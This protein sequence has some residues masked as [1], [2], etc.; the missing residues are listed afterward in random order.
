MKRYAARGLGT[1]LF[2]C[3]ALAALTVSALAAEQ[4]PCDGSHGEGW[5]ALTLDYLANN[6]YTLPMGNYYL[7]EDIDHGKQIEIDSKTINL[8]LNGHYYE[9]T[10]D[11]GIFRVGTGGVLNICDCKG[12][13]KIW[14]TEYQNPVLLHDGGACNLYGGTLQSTRS[15]MVIGDSKDRGVAGGTFTMYGGTVRST[16]SSNYQGIKVNTN[17]TD[18]AV[19]IYGGT[20]SSGRYGISAGSGAVTLKGSP[21]ISGGTADIYLNGATIVP[22]GT[23]SGSVS[24]KM[25]TPGVFTGADKS[26]Y[27]TNFTS[28]DP[29]YIVQ[30]TDSGALK[31][32]RRPSHY[33]CVCGEA[34][35]GEHGAPVGFTELTA[36]GGTLQGGSYYLSGAVT[37]T[38]N[39][40]ISGTVNLCLNGQELNLNENRITINSGGSLTLCDC[41]AQ[42]DGKITG[43]SS[44]N[45]GAVKVEGSFTMYS[46]AISGNGSTGDV[47]GGVY[48]TGEGS[49][50]M[51]GGSITDNTARDGGG[52]YI[53]GGGSFTM[54]NGTISG[55]TAIGN[56][57]G[58]HINSGAFTMESGT[59]SDNASTGNFGGGVYVYSNGNFTM[60]GGAITGNTA[61]D[62]GGVYIDRGS[63]TVSGAPSVSGNRTNSGNTTKNVYLAYSAQNRFI[64][65]GEGGL[66]NSTSIS[67]SMST[68]DVFTNGWSDYMSGQ[69]PA[70]YFT[71]DNSA[72]VVILKDGEAALHE[73]L[74]QYSADDDADTFT[75]TCSCGH[76]ATA[77]VEKPTQPT[78]DGSAKDVTVT[79][80][81][82]WVG[83][84][85]PSITYEKDGATAESAVDAGDYTAQVTLKSATVTV[86]FTIE[87]ASQA[88]P[89]D[90]EGYTIDYGAET[91]AVGAG[92]EV[93]T[94]ENSGEAVTSGSIEDYL[95]DTLY[96]RR[97]EDSN[98]HS[99]P[100]TGFLV[101]ARPAEPSV[102]V[103]NESVKGKGD[104]SVSGITDKMEYSTDGG[105]NWTQGPATLE[106][107]P[108]GTQVTVRVKATAS[109]PHGEALLRT[110]AGSDKTLTVTFDASGGNAV[111]AVTGLSYDQIVAQPTTSRTGYTLE[112][113]YLSDTKWDFGSGVQAD[114]TLTARWALEAPTVTVEADPADG[115]AAFGQTVTLTA[116][117]VHAATVSW[118]YQWYKGSDMLPGETGET[119]EL[120]EA[121]HTGSYHVVVTASDGSQ[122]KTAQSAAVDVTIQKTPATV[123]EWPTASAITYGESLERSTLSGG[124]TSGT[125]AWQD[126]TIAPAVAN[127]GVTGYTVVFTPHDPNY[128]PVTSTVT[129]T[130]EAKALTPSV[131]SVSDK[132][133]DGT[134][135]ASGV[136]AL[137]GAVFGEAPTAK[138]TFTFSGK[139]AG[140]GKAVTVTGIALEGD[141]GENYV[142]SVT[143]LS[144]T[145]DITPR[146][147]GLTWQGH[148][149]L[150]YTGAPVNVTAT[151]TGLMKGDR[152]AVTVEGGDGV[153]AGPYTARATGL[154]NDNYALPADVELSYTIQKADGAASVSLAGWTY[155]ETPNVP[156]L[157]SATN[158][159]AGVTYRY[160]GTTN[161]GA[162]Y[163][164]AVPP[165]QA[166][167][168]TLTATFPATPNY[169][170]VS[171]MAAFT[172]ARRSITGTWQGL[173]QVYGDGGT[174]SLLLQGLLPE[175]AGLQATI[176]GVGT[177]AGRYPLTAT[178]DNYAITPA[179][180]TLVV[181]PQAVTVTVTDNAA[182]AGEPFTGAEVTV[183]VPDSSDYQVVYKDQDGQVV[184]APTT[185][186]TYEIWVELLDD[187]YRH[188]DGSTEKQVGTF[189]V[190][191]G[192]PTL[193]AVT[194]DGGEGSGGSMDPLSLAGGSVLLLPECGYERTGHRFAG[195]DQGGKTY[196]SGDRFTMPHADVTFTARWVQVHDAPIT[197][198]DH[199]GTSVEDAVISVSQGAEELTEDRT[200]QNGAYTIPDLAPGDYNVSVTVGDKTVTTVVTVGE[201]GTVT[202]G[203]ISLPEHGTSTRVEVSPGSPDVVVD[204]LENGFTE[205]DKETAQD[206]G[207]VEIIVRVEK[208]SPQGGQEEDAEALHLDISLDK[209]TTPPGGGEPVI[210]E[211]IS[212]DKPLTVTI[213]LPTE[214]KGKDDYTVTRA[215]NGESGSLSTTPDPVTGEYF[216]LSEDGERIILH[217][218]DSAL[219]TVGGEEAKAPPVY[220]PVKNESENGS[221]TVSPSWPVYGQEVTVTP[222]P[223][224]GYE[225]DSVTVTDRNGNPVEVTEKGDGTYTFTQPMGNVTVT[226]T[227]RPA[228]VA[229]CPRDESCPLAAFGDL[230]VHAW[231]H[232]GVHFCLEEGLMAGYGDGIFA[233]DDA[234]SRGMLAQIPYNREGRP[235]VSGT[236][237]FADVSGEDWYAD[238]IAWAAASGIVEGYGDGNYGPGD[239]ATWE[240]LIALLYR[241]AQYKGYDVS[242]GNGSTSGSSQV[243]QW[244][245]AA[246]EWALGAGVLEENDALSSGAVITR[247]QAAAILLWLGTV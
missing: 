120:T 234:L 56:G 161:G 126:D 78:Y 93:Y 74:Y 48:I 243:S 58:V 216:E 219:Y 68:A 168:Y 239:S 119:L 124:D 128:S 46:G 88:K 97:P 21:S 167:S 142:L 59:I 87:K 57:G 26:S 231:Y 24:V 174:V 150:V 10:T 19:Y 197:V 240:Q 118:S 154:D 230:E 202:G 245:Q 29:D 49:F 182:T 158:G 227:F 137:D 66:S 96:I 200:D 13:G 28:A 115:S 242:A 170:A 169:N 214:L 109:A 98:H 135:S 60:E 151:A 86:T 113:W 30:A 218:A 38:S 212:A 172:V 232:D 244:A 246:M 43:G 25:E 99:S 149:A 215:G 237:P 211:G 138:G 223:G 148:E 91:I 82:S 183:S 206:G 101:S 201:D 127:S 198:T 16:A 225:V 116:R 3:A 221:F 235:A 7:A 67:V 203:D 69:D 23:L 166:G 185:P 76:T 100:W 236:L 208:T 204:D 1:L 102:T 64:T 62:G 83:S 5:T 42:G 195:W 35:C 190:T 121:S 199:T 95:G 153:D 44:T 73:H 17:L 20:I 171:A 18:T 193:Y 160:T 224:E 92:F 233:P 131:Q 31:L 79:F 12:G 155:G 247:A 105:T 144:G 55:N 32:A 123:H 50:I 81:D 130:V 107:L 213:P 189:T 112:G 229:G 94:A 65:I 178:L 145:A 175:D 104:G 176:T 186:G 207:K 63:F 39:I 11:D 106:N 53:T 165:T 163:D 184:T 84:R 180:A 111:E 222:K 85:S 129:V 34:S 157:S 134:T 122:S 72:Y 162:A 136:I 108:A 51:E 210:E 205:E 241:Y 220:P 47:G 173:S 45:G 179:K 226:V 209:I 40:T 52:V 33:H 89:G 238:A 191:D 77:T 140:P 22:E 54:K 146:P 147:V 139:D 36:L 90:G 41:S 80:G 132:F 152:C 9:S 27:L 181:Q 194:F 125:F 217:V 188:D 15:A 37:A 156:A 159:T 6:S 14:T 103:T 117:P 114:I 133:Y 61:R 2:L 187:N 164:S 71:P 75:E 177:D 70:N 143:E 8:C 228:G 4:P 196:R 192:A 110:I 141:W